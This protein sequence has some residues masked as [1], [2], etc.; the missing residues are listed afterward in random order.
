MVMPAEDL[1]RTANPII[2]SLLKA[3]CISKADGKYASW[4]LPDIQKKMQ[5][6]SA[7]IK[8][9]A[10]QPECCL[11]HHY[12]W[13]ADREKRVAYELAARDDIKTIGIDS[14]GSMV[15]DICYANYGQA[16][17]TLDPNE[18][19]FAP[20]QAMNQEIRAF[21]NAITHKNVILTHQLS[22]VWQNGKPTKMTKPTS[23][24]SK[25]GHYTSISAKLTLNKEVDVAAG[26]PRYTLSC[27]DCQANAS[28]IG[29][30]LLFDAGINFQALA[31][32]VYEDSESSDWE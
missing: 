17:G 31:Q 8:L 24:F 23:S 16:M 28:L 10:P 29:L 9:S 15:E 30:D 27:L 20:R 7:D 1:I 12:R 14:W 22:S 18:F 3:Q 26:E 21:L 2:T 4:S 13:F 11:R 6:I 19:G 25:I 5:E 32:L